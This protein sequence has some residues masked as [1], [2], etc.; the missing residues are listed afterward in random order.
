MKAVRSELQICF[1]CTLILYADP[2]LH[3][4]GKINRSFVLS[5]YPK[6][7][8]LSSREKLASIHQDAASCKSRLGAAGS[9]V[10]QWLAQTSTPGLNSEKLV[11]LRV[12]YWDR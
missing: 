10:P 11:N 12:A 3:V 5:E 1:A 9:R 2:G 6:S 7:S 8:R 4:F